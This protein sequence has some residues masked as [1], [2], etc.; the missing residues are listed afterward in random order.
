MTDR[1]QELADLIIEAL[2]QRTAR[3]HSTLYKYAWKKRA[4]PL[5]NEVDALRATAARGEKAAPWATSAVHDTHGMDVKRYDESG[6]VE[7]RSGALQDQVQ[8]TDWLTPR[9]SENVQT[10]LDEIA[11]KGS[12][13][14]GQGRGATVATMA[15]LSDRPTPN[16][17]AGGQT[18][19]GGERKGELLIGGLAQLAPWPTAT[20]EDARS[21]RRHGYMITGQQGTTLTDAANLA[22]APRPT[23]RAEDAECTGAHRGVP[24][25]LTSASELTSWGTPTAQ[26]AKH[27]C[28]SP[29]EMLCDPNVLRNQAHLASWPTPNALDTMDRETM[30]P[31]RAA[32]GRKVGY[33][34]EAVA[35]YAKP[36][37]EPTCEEDPQAAPWATPASRDW[38]DGRASE[39]TMEKNARPLNE[40]AVSL[41]PWP[42]PMSV[43]DSEASHNQISGQ[44]RRQMA[45]CSPWP[46]PVAQP[47][48]GTPEAFLERKRKAV[49]NGS[50]MGI[51][52][53]DIAMAA[54]LTAPEAA[55]PT[56]RGQDSYERRNWKTMT[57]I[58]EEGGDMTLVTAVKTRLQAPP[59]ASGETA[60]GSPAATEKRGQLNPSLPRWLMSIPEAWDL[61][62]PP[63]RIP[64]RTSRRS[65]SAR[66]PASE[67]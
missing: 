32:T 67:D 1:E 13:W 65:S 55:W 42:T 36:E 46:T 45:K 14:L 50:T 7:G 15:Q 12:S 6:K 58:A 30:R 17:M 3:L 40:Q 47:A 5:G 51:C 25:T 2:Y 34:T 49:A 22:G 9:S 21:S 8:L 23:P 59:E 10:N 38:R 39:E 64:Q 48:N 66:K 20:K 53:S 35:T 11:A 27:G 16:A 4:T 29:S 24:D 18:S 31:S 61:C 57:K 43:P 62:I 60:S 63:K 26:D 56:P 41:A 33:L 54:D 37:G 19:R 28:L 44:Y 52:I